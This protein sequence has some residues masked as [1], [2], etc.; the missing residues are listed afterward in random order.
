M[1]FVSSVAYG[2][3]Y[4]LAHLVLVNSM[5]A[6]IGVLTTEVACCKTILE[7]VLN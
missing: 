3:G 5:H 7:V 2:Y 1:A 6:K 4:Y